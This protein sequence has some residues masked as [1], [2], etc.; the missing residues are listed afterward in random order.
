MAGSALM[1]LI[2]T[3]PAPLLFTIGQEY[4]PWIA[5]GMGSIPALGIIVG[6]PVAGLLVRRLGTRGLL[7]PSFVIYGCVGPAPL[8]I[9]DPYVLLASR[10]VL[11]FSAA[12]AVAAGL[13]IISSRYEG[14]AR[15]RILGIQG[16]IAAVVGLIALKASALIAVAGSWRSPFAL[17]SVGFGLFAIALVVIDREPA[18]HAS[19]TAEARTPSRALWVYWR[20]YA[21]I[22]LLFA[23]TFSTGLQLSFKL[24]D[25]GI[26]DPGTQSNVILAAS[27]LSAIG[28]A[29]YGF[30]VP[31]LGE[32]ATLVLLIALM[33]TGAFVIGLGQEALVI[34]CGAGIMGLG[35]GMTGP[36]LIGKL[37]ARVTEA[38]R[39]AA[40]G[41]AYSCI[42]IGEFVNPLFMQP[43]R[44][45]VTTDGAFL[46]L[47]ALLSLGAV[48]GLR[49][50]RSRVKEGVDP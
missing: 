47:A 39:A 13:A 41:F 43:L 6:G 23:A 11:G 28:S 15:L 26:V 1:A 19:E 18:A 4:G 44:S 50:A 36:H 48:C 9:D 30:I 24:G 38:Q 25:H 22:V 45:A 32:R 5:Q 2:F 12:A 10:F 27:L 16:S 42:F 40:V 8:L 17:Y 3:V 29:T 37:M 31:K 33:A 14:T 7:L 35:G 46:T 20:D 21:V 49:S 34:A